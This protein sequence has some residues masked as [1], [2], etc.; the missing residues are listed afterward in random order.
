M[1][2]TFLHAVQCKYYWWGCRRFLNLITLR[3]E[4][5]KA[6][7]IYSSSIRRSIQLIL[8]NKCYEF[9]ETVPHRWNLPD[10]SKAKHQ[11]HRYTLLPLEKRYLFSFPPFRCI[12][13]M[14]RLF[15]VNSVCNCVILFATIH[16]LS[17]CTSLFLHQRENL[18]QL[19]SADRQQTKLYTMYTCK[20][21]Q[22]APSLIKS[23]RSVGCPC[24]TS[25]YAGLLVSCHMV[26]IVSMHFF[27]FPDLQR[28]IERA[29]ISRLFGTEPL[30][31]VAMT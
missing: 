19:F 12:V 30:Y 28:L 5:V 18:S 26:N 27:H 2:S 23:K 3:S 4:W 11:G 14:K 13:G 15:C 8:Q 16:T 10:L 21:V 29:A 7:E 20:L 17:C 22:I 1:K 25:N 9:T 31:V 6:L 24:R